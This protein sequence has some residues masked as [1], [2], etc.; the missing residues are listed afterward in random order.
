MRRYLF[1]SNALN[2]FLDG[3]SPFADRAREARLRGDHLGTCELVV[4]ELCFGLEFSS[5]REQNLERL[6][7]GLSRLRSWPFDR[8]AAVEYARIAAELRRRGRPMQVVDMMLAA[9]ALS[10]GG[11]VITT[12]TD[13][14]A[15]PGLSV[16]NWT[17]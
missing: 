12:D 2:A 10:V 15:V 13:L 7:R 4:A 9:V 8:S 1:D 5:S 6:W 14:Q 3:R 11:T 16:Q 17:T